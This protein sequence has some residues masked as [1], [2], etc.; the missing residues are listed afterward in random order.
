MHIY[1][2]INHTSTV[3]DVALFINHTMHAHSREDKRLTSKMLLTT[4]E[5]LVE[6]CAITREQLNFI[7]INQ[8]PGMF[9]TL[10]SIIATVNGIY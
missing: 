4:I 3:Y 6:R 2:V 9:S 10:R 7:A 8:G 1:I 5:T